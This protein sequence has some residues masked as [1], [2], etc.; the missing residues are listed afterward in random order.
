MAEDWGE[1]R[2]KIFADES[3]EYI[4]VHVLRWF[5]RSVRGCNYHAL[6][7]VVVSTGFGGMA[8]GGATIVAGAQGW[9][10]IS[11]GTNVAPAFSMAVRTPSINS[12]ILL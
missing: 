3:G 4:K 7:N 10:P 11:I 5:V 1:E 9:V 12:T 6:R 8:G 2:K